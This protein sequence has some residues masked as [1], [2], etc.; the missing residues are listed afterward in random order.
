VLKVMTNKHDM[1]VD[2]ELQGRQSRSKSFEKGNDIVDILVHEENCLNIYDVCLAEIEHH[3]THI[4]EVPCATNL[5]QD[6]EF[7]D[8]R[9]NILEKNEHVNKCTGNIMKGNAMCSMILQGE[10][11][12]M[13]QIQLQFVLV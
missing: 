6:I 10:K 11:I 2:N 4:V 8:K 5:T 7:V 9:N 3:C 13:C 1:L 12:L